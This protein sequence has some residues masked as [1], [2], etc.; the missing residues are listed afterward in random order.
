MPFLRNQ[1][2][3]KASDAITEPFKSK[4]IGFCLFY[5]IST[6]IDTRCLSTSHPNHFAY[7][8]Q[9]HSIGFQMFDTFIGKINA[10]NFIIIRTK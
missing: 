10:S 6:S 5:P 3:E 1:E 8:L 4:P 9:N 7:P 2:M